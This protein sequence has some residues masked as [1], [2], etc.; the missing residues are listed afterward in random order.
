MYICKY[1]F[2]KIKILRY[3]ENKYV[4]YGK[5]NIWIGTTTR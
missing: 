3:V 1:N 5:R 4:I 2:I